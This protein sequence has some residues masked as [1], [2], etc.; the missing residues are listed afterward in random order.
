MRILM[1]E[2]E[3]YMAEVWGCPLP[4]LLL[5]DWAARYRSPVWKT[6]LRL[7]VL[8]WDC[9]R[10]V[11]HARFWHRSSCLSGQGKCRICRRSCR[12]T[13]GL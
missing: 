12:Y 1:V 2:D 6:N 13:P 3:K 8:R 11:S 7:L 4:K 5:T 10:M 9:D